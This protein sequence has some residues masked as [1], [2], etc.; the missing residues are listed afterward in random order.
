MVRGIATALS[1]L[2]EDFLP[3]YKVRL[4]GGLPHPSKNDSVVYF[5]RVWGGL[6]H[7][8][9]NDSEGLLT[10]VLGHQI[11]AIGPPWGS[12]THAGTIKKSR[13]RDSVE[14]LRRELAVGWS[15]SP[16]D[17]LLAPL[18]IAERLTDP[19]LLPEV[20]SRP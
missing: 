12:C 3:S 1:A 6:L 13:T 15:G 14:S 7:P 16:P 8:S 11:G 18:G 5:S 9:R 10:W 2:E 4:R 17:A 20:R 19:L